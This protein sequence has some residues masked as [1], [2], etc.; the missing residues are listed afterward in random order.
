[1]DIPSNS[2][3]A[4]GRI[5]G[6]HGIRGQVR[7][8]SYSG[9]LASLQSVQEILLR[10]PTGSVLKV[11]I[12][13]AVNHSGKILLTLDGYNDIDQALKLVGGELLLQR[14]RL[15]ATEPDEYYW[16]DLLGLNVITDEGRFLGVVSDIMETGAN[17]VY[18]VRNEETRHEYLIPAIGS[19]ISKIDLQTGTMTITPLEGLLEL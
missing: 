3:I 9:N 2:L 19:V 13:R 12:K 18:I 5:S 14:D 10:L 1:M 7:L 11:L 4:V 8:H 17:D 16:Q 6:T 15:P